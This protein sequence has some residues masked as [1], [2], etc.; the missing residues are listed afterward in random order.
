MASSAVLAK[1]ILDWIQDN[2]VQTALGAFDMMLFLGPMTIMTPIL[3]VLGF[4]GGGPFHWLRE[5]LGIHD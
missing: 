1:P 4:G 5:S 3:T 2:P